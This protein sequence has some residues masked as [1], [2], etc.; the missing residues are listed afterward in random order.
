M[1]SEASVRYT[2]RRVD[3]GS[4]AR[5]GC[6]LGWLAA[7]PPALCLAGLSVALLQRLA[8]T[9]AQIQPL[10]LDVFGQELARIDFLQVLHLQTFAVMLATYMS[11]PVVT[12]LLIAVVLIAGGGAVLMVTAVLI[13]LTYNLVA[14]AGGGLTV[15]LRAERPRTGEPGQN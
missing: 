8:E 13:G 14:S 10:T 1:R 7:L 2:I 3:L 12:F 6:L 5:L 4:T 9:L 11:E 15:E